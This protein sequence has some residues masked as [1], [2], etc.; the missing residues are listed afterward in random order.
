MKNIFPFHVFVHSPLENV[1]ALFTTHRCGHVR[2]NT[3]HNIPENGEFSSVNHFEH[4]VKSDEAFV[5]ILSIRLCRPGL[6]SNRCLLY[7]DLVQNVSDF[8][9]LFQEPWVDLSCFDD[10]F[11]EVEEIYLH[12]KRALHHRPLVEYWQQSVL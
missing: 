10:G 3:Q 8:M 5:S 1:K 4:L 2:Q 11:W 7:D 12:C 6:F 9:E